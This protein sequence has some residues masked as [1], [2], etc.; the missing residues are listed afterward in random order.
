MTREEIDMFIEAMADI[1]VHY[2]PEQVEE[3]FGGLSLMEAA[4]KRLNRMETFWNFV[5]EQVIPDVQKYGLW[6]G[7]DPYEVR[8]N[9]RGR[10]KE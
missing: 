10:K 3:E 9:A 8:N 7:R 1:G 2:T 6:D 4:Q 5:E